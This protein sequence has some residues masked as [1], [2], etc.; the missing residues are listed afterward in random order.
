MADYARFMQEVCCNEDQSRWLQ[1]KLRDVVEGEE[2]PV[3]DVIVKP[4]RLVLHSE[5]HGNPEKVAVVLSHFLETYSPGISFRFE[6][7]YGHGNWDP[8]YFGA[9]A[10]FITAEGLEFMGACDWLR[11][12]AARWEATKKTKAWGKALGL[13]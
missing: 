9:V 13:D 11:E 5:R 2:P 8:G 1:Q 12:R 6:V 3:C 7:C 4:D 10:I